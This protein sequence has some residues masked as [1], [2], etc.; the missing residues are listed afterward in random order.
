M[1]PTISHSGKGKPIKTVKN[2]VVF[3]DWERGRGSIGR[4]Q[5][6]VKAVKLFCIRL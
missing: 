5:R 1:I 4:A 2:S 6:T 3:R